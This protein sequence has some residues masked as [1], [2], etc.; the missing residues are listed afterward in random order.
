[1]A[2]GLDVLAG[3]SID[4]G[5]AMVAA[6]LHAASG[7]LRSELNCAVSPLAR[8]FRA[9]DQ[10]TIAAQLGEADLTEAQMQGAQL[11]AVQA[12]AFAA[13]SRG[14]RRRPRYGWDSLT[15]TER[16]VADLVC[17][18]LS[19]PEIGAALLIAEGTVRT[20][21]RST[22]AKLGFRSRAELAAEVARRKG[23]S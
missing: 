21:L 16:Q 10:Q 19:N 9:N 3:L 20:H 18:G 1:V 17:D 15:P 13:R 12:V 14:P 5:R 2:D 8:Q 6:Q 7:R 11:D 4:G 22:F 23:D